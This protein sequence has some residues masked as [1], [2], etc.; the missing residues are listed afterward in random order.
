[1]DKQFNY[2]II[3]NYLPNNVS[4]EIENIMLKN[5]LPWFFINNKSADKVL[6]Q[7]D[8][9]Q[10]FQFSHMFYADYTILSN[11]YVNIVKPII[12]KLNPLSLIRVKG[13]LTTV[14]PNIIKYGWHTD[15][16]DNY[17]HKTAI[18]YVNTNNGKTI[19]KNGLEVESVKNR[20]V[21]FD[22]WMEHTATSSTDTKARCVLNL[23]Y[24]ERSK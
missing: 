11:Y 12:D 3:D 20:I 19:F 7:W 18:Y 15:V 5:T 22:G 10:N 4:D 13:N 9:I 21:I 2:E 8:D 14:T 17:E 6:M 1:M 24:I 16:G 23:N